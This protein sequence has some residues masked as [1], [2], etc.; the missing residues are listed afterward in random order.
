MSVMFDQSIVLAGSV[1]G[2]AESLPHS[3]VVFVIEDVDAASEVVTRRDQGQGSSTAACGN[4]ASSSP[5]K[6]AAGSSGSSSSKPPDSNS[7]PIILKDEQS[8]KLNL[9]TLLNVLD[10]VIDTP[11]RIIVMTT[12]FPEL[13]E[14]IRPGRIN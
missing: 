2:S 9:A 14:L 12:N 11:E 5:D 8:D 13:L 3:R 1:H 10:G 6:A 4:V 7:S